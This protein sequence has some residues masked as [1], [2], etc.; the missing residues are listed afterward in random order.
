MRLDSAVAAQKPLSQLLRVYIRGGAGYLWATY[1]ERE[2]RRNVTT[3]KYSYPSFIQA[4]GRDTAVLLAL[5]LLFEAEP[6]IRF[7]VEGS[8]RQAKVSGF[9][10]EDKIG[11]TGTLYFVEEYDPDLEYWQRKYVISPE[12]PSGENYRSIKEAEVDFG[13]LS[14]KLGIMIRF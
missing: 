2:S 10:G 4:S 12:A 6:G 7:F 11:T 14:I 13:G 1:V 8:W 5:G 3:E 9:T